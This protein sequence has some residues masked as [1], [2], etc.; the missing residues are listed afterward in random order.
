MAL[1]TVITAD[2]IGSRKYKDKQALQSNIEDALNVLNTEHEGII[3]SRFSML[4]GDEI[5]GLIDSPVYIAPLIRH[6]RFYTRP[7]IIRVGIGIGN[8]ATPIE[9]N[10]PWH[11]DGDAFHKAREA[12]DSIKH[13]KRQA[14][15]LISG[16]KNTDDNVNI[17]FALMDAI[18]SRW[19]D[20]QWEAVHAYEK[21]KTYSNA[22]AVLGITMQNV[23]KRCWAAHWDAFNKAEIH[24]SH[25]LS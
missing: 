18:N 12:V 5:Q 1:Y 24:I 8:I 22:A 7:V 11:M 23:A 21:T 6:M 10:N 25:L 17:I 14:T 4:R 15:V 9:Q 13:I 20:A 19:T 3:L 16:E 2:I